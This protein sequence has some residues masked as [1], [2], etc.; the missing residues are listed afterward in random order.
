MLRLWF[1]TIDSSGFEN[2]THHSL[3][4]TQVKTTQATKH[5]QWSWYCHHVEVLTLEPGKLGCIHSPLSPPHSDSFQVFCGSLRSTVWATLFEG[6]PECLSPPPP[7]HHR[8]HVHPQHH[9][10][11]PPPTIITTYSDERIYS[12]NDNLKDHSLFSLCSKHTI[13]L[14][15]TLWLR[16]YLNNTLCINQSLLTVLSIHK[17]MF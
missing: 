4:S 5:K 16:Q 2:T 9:C 1:S 13:I 12:K 14:K 11:L 15:R 6:I 8:H 17:S 10:A 7:H 3:L